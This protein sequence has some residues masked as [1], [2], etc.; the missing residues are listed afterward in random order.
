MSFIAAQRHVLSPA[1]REYA[2]FYRIG[3]VDQDLPACNSL[4]RLIYI[5]TIWIGDNVYVIKN[6]ATQLVREFE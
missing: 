1:D 4:N 5:E 6:K 3:T 2:T